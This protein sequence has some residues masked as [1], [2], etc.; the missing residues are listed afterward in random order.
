MPLPE[1]HIFCA[2]MGIKLPFLENGHMR[3]TLWPSENLLRLSPSIPLMQ[4][5]MFF[6]MTN[7]LLTTMLPEDLNSRPVSTGWRLVTR[8]QRIFFMLFEPVIPMLRL[9]ILSKA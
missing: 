4:I 6:A 9:K 2:S 7:K 5:C 1:L 3:L 8:P